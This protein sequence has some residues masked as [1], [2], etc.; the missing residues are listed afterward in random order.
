MVE[1]QVLQ[2]ALGI[3]LNSAASGG[4]GVV[5]IFSWRG[6]TKITFFPLLEAAFSIRVE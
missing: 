3:L 2:E 1:L 4:K 6:T 5:L